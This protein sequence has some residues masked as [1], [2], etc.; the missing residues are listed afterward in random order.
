MTTVLVAID[1]SECAL[2]AI[3]HLLAL[4]ARYRNPGELV[5]HLVNVQPQL[6]TDIGRFFSQAQVSDFHRQESA[7]ALEGAQALLDAAGAAYTSHIEVGHVADV[8]AR[9]ADSLE[10]EQI[11][12]G[13]HGRGT[14]A[15]L[16]VGST[17][18]KVVHL[19]RVPV[20][21]VK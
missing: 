17:T 1:G 7:K 4:R 10:C 9:L 6:S 18:M 5:I 15:E 20:L 21:L 16:L 19:A 2:R 8:I 12:M 14:L 3:R 13:T 11:V